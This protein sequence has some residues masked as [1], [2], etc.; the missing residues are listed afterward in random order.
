MGSPIDININITVTHE[1]SIEF[2]KT[3][4]RAK[5]LAVKKAEEAA[6]QEVV[7]EEKKE[8]ASKFVFEHEYLPV[9]YGVHNRL[10]KEFP[11][12]DLMKM[13]KDVSSTLQSPIEN[14]YPFLKACARKYRQQG[15]GGGDFV[16]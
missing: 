9:G 15:V 14:P 12:I 13:Y 6:K 16:Y 10:Q 4:P 5:K 1:G 2:I 8:P 7:K 11:K 3:T